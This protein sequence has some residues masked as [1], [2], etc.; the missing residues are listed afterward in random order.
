MKGVCF[1][2]KCGLGKGVVVSCSEAILRL[3]I[4]LL[5]S[6]G[7]SMEWKKAW[8]EESGKLYSDCGLASTSER[9]LGQGPVPPWASF[10]SSGCGQSD[11]ASAQT[12]G[13]KPYEVGGAALH[14]NVQSA[15]VL[16]ANWPR[17]ALPDCVWET[18]QGGPQVFLPERDLG[19]KLP[20]W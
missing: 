5:E 4:S 19:K 6:S 1:C 20:G 18:R 9:G 11:R 15:Q 7:N 3:L 10:L 2:W 16:A 8:G 14:T 13:G 12:G 17:Q